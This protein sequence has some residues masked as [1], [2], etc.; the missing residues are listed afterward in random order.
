[1]KTVDSILYLLRGITFNSANQDYIHPNINS[2]RVE[3][4]VLHLSWPNSGFQ[5]E[6]EAPMSDQ[7]CGATNT[8]YF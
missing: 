6:F 3:E 8:V 1:M 5:G 2:F 4:T 7:M